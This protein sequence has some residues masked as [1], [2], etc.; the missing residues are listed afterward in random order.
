[1]RGRPRVAIVLTAPERT[2]LRRLSTDGDRQV[3]RRADIVLR[4]A[5]GQANTEIAQ[6]LGVDEKTVSKWRR[7]F[8]DHRVDGLRKPE[9][10]APPPAADAKPGFGRR[11]VPT[12]VADEGLVTQRRA[13]IVAAALDLFRRRGYGATS[14]SEIAEAA[15]LPIG[16]LYRY[17][18]KKSD[19][20]YLLTQDIMPSLIEAIETSSQVGT[21]PE[22]KL[23]LG[24]RGYLA[25]VAQRRV[26]IKI[27]YW[28]T[29]WLEPHEQA[30]IKAEEE[31]TRQLIE[32]LIEGGIEAGA[33][34]PVNVLVAAENVILAGHAWALKGFMLRDQIS[35]DDYITEQ[36]ELLVDGLRSNGTGSAGRRR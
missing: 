17:I 5:S 30:V 2:A 6:Q 22:E 26:H 11:V 18:T 32:R 33:L 12:G 35:L 15:G 10:L 14:V 29:H 28:D 9:P 21:T 24:I 16:T 36:V 13:K 31:R 27:M 3:A 20:L 8:L 25:A 1:M 19:I 7:K 23:R 34:R 4:S